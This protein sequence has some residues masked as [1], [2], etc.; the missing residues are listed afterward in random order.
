MKSFRFKPFIIISVIVHMIVFSVL[1]VI[2]LR[3][4]IK[5]SEPTP[6]SFGVI[7]QNNGSIS[8]SHSNSRSQTKAVSGKEKALKLKDSNVIDTL[9]VKHK[10]KTTEMTNKEFERGALERNDL[11]ELI[12]NENDETK[13]EN[14]SLSTSKGQTESYTDENKFADVGGG[15]DYKPNGGITSKSSGQGLEIAHPDYKV[16][17]KPKYP[18]IARRK[19][20]EGSVL[21]RIW[22]LESGGVGKIE[23][24]K[25]SG[26]HVLDNSALD[27]VKD[28][29]FIP[30]MRNGVPVS[31]WVTVP[32]RFQLDSG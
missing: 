14:G 23:L 16:N 8:K 7:S 2:L 27:A 28:W 4:D 19:G 29:I 30:G 26:F 3:R 31:S 24:E 9:L 13:I 18:M 32:I 17:P 12:D 11:K 15:S 20:Y 1:G 10:A 21:L 6:I 5:Y 22:V 25:S